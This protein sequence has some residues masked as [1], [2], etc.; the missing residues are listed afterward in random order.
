MSTEKVSVTELDRWVRQFAALVTANEDL[1]TRLDSV[2][3]DGDHGENLRRGVS[4]VLVCLDEETAERPSVLL[5]LVGKRLV[6]TVGGTSGALYGTFFLRMGAAAGDAEF[7]DSRDIARCFRAG[8]EGLIARGKAEAGDKTMCDA[9]IPAV[10]AFEREVAGGVPLARAL[11]AADAA[12]RAG[13]DA[14]ASM[15]ARKGRAS[16]LGDRSIG[17]QDAGATSAA[18][19]FDAAARTMCR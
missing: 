12:A 10:Q 17:H 8:L 6:S 9:V 4:A 7:L 11:Q 14:T 16:Y 18:M 13:R 3:G 1:I 2:I 19:L 5:K 15:V